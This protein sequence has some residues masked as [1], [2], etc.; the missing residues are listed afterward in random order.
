MKKYSKKII[1]LIIVAIV[2]FW[3]T[4]TLLIALTGNGYPS[5]FVYAWFTFWSVE[6]VA[7]AGIKITETH[8]SIY[9]CPDDEDING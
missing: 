8:T 7:M 9:K 6:L 2:V 3:L 5:Y 1:L 4:E